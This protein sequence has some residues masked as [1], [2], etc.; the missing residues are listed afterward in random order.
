MSIAP[1]DEYEVQVRSFCDAV[2]GDSPLKW[3][4]EDAVAQMKVIDVLRESAQLNK[5]IALDW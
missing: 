3:G 2:R 5:P 1:T 4:C